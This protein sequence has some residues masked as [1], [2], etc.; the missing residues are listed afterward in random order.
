MDDITRN[1]IDAYSK[2]EDSISFTQ[3]L[4]ELKEDAVKFSEAKA[5]G[6]SKGLVY[7]SYGGQ[8]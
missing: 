5:Y 1:K 3:L 6:E 4:Y 2:A 8:G 7:L